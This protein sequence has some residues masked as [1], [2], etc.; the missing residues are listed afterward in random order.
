MTSVAFPS[1]SIRTK[2][3]DGTTYSYLHVKPADE[4]PYILFLHGFPSSSYDWR[5]QVTYFSEEG[6]GLIVPDLLGYGDTDKPRELEAY[7]LRKMAEEIVS[8]LDAQQV[9]KA[10][11]VGHDW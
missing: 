3:P 1:L 8:L 9:D 5:H 2:A 6:Y 4:K 10:V 11:G 7:R